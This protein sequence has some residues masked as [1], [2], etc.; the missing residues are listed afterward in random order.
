MRPKIIYCGIATGATGTSA[1]FP[2]SERNANRVLFN[3]SVIMKHCCSSAF[4]MSSKL[5]YYLK[6]NITDWVHTYCPS[7]V[8]QM[9]LLMCSKKPFWREQSFSMREADGWH[10]Y[11]T[12]I[13]ENSLLDLSHHL[14]S[15]QSFQF[16]FWRLVS[17]ISTVGG[18][19]NNTL[20]VTLQTMAW[21]DISVQK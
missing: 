2:H 5:I 4:V 21:T 13:S 12:A 8:P 3:F 1:F 18:S 15:L 6:I 19:F 14:Q 11:Q 9:L 20:P 10:H 17:A 16:T 7:C